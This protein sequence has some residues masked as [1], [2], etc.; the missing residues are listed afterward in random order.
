MQQKYYYEKPK[1]AEENKD[2]SEKVWK[3][4]GYRIKRGES[5]SYRFY[6]K[7]IY[8][9]NQ[10]EKIGSY[11]IKYSPEGLAKKLLEDTK[12]PKHTI[13]ILVKNYNM[14]EYDAKRLVIYKKFNDL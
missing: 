3:K 12:S 6:G 7:E 1:S 8:T 14:T 2:H 4:L 10:V 13:N 5:Y 9:P 11:E